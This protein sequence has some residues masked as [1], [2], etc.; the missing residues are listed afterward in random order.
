MAFLKHALWTPALLLWAVALVLLLLDPAHGQATISFNVS[1]T[2]GSASCTSGNCNTNET[3]AP[4]FAC[5]D[6]R[7]NWN[8]GNALFMDPIPP[9][10][11]FVLWNITATAYGRFDCNGTYS[12]NILGIIIIAGNYLLLYHPFVYSFA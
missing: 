1:F 9:N 4:D 12:D 8:D 2:G 7:G 10:N 11:G 6:G 5:S 3:Y